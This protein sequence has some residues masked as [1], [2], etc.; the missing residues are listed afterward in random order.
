MR[1]VG[2]RFPYEPERPSDPILF[3]KWCQ[4]RKLGFEKRSYPNYGFKDSR[5]FIYR[6]KLERCFEAHDGCVNTIAWNQ[7]GRLLL[8]GSDDLLLKISDPFE[9]RILTTIQSGHRSNIFSAK[10]LPFSDDAKIVSCSGDGQLMYTEVL[11]PDT[12]GSFRFTC[13]QGSTANVETIEQEPNSFMSCGEDGTVR[14]FDIRTRTSCKK[15]FRCNHD[16]IYKSSCGVSSLAVNQLVPYQM[17]VCCTDGIVRLMD[18]RFMH[19]TGSNRDLKGAFIRFCPLKSP[20]EGE[21][22]DRPVRKRI[23]SVKF[24]P[25]TGQEVLVSYS[26]DSLYLFGVDGKYSCYRRSA[27]EQVLCSERQTD[28]REAMGT[29]TVSQERTQHIKLPESSEGQPTTEGN[30]DVGSRSIFRRLRIRGD[31][32][33][34]GPQAR[35]QQTARNQA[36]AASTDED[37]AVTITTTNT[38]SGDQG[39]EAGQ[40][41]E[42]RNDSGSGATG[43]GSGRSR[44]TA[45]RL[46][47]I[48]SEL[49]EQQFGD[50]QPQPLGQRQDSNQQSMESLE[51]P[52]SSSQANSAYASQTSGS[53][54]GVQPQQISEITTATDSDRSSLLVMRDLDH[55]VQNIASAP[56]ES[57]TDGRPNVDEEASYEEQRLSYIQQVHEEVRNAPPVDES[58]PASGIVFVREDVSNRGASL[59]NSTDSSGINVYVGTGRSQSEEARTPQLNPH[60]VSTV[61]NPT[62]TTQGNDDSTFVVEPS[63]NPAFSRTASEPLTVQVDSGESQPANQR[64]ETRWANVTSG[65]MSMIRAQNRAVA[66]SAARRRT[67]FRRR[68]RRWNM[69]TDDGANETSNTSNINSETVEGQRSSEDEEETDSGDDDQ[70]KKDAEIL[71]ILG[72]PNAAVRVRFS[73]HRNTRTMIKQANFWGSEHVVTGSDCGHVFIYER[74]SGKLVTVLEADSHVVNGVQPHPTNCVLASSGIDYNI[75][76]WTP[77][78]PP[79]MPPPGHMLELIER[80]IVMQRQTRDLITVPASLML[81]LLAI[82]SNR[83]QRGQDTTSATANDAATEEATRAT[84]DG[85][86]N[87]QDETDELQDRESGTDYSSDSD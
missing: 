3:P 27:N 53:N 10:F 82:A 35:P 36:P 52:G 87:N 17:A 49:L 28:K 73:G 7:N 37:N 11:R 9:G 85:A 78:G 60:S 48:L 55:S 13:H 59:N 79:N 45:A 24:C 57:S 15:R 51:D 18:R 47:N 4:E 33:D 40:L 38:S 64:A 71:G 76:I 42:S 5:S 25:Q 62:I 67:D 75:K 23:T 22:S 74:Y 83:N 32:S 34:T 80:N 1:C 41:E 8:S 77:T 72:L 19:P 20:N 81:R 16:V 2:R 26:G 69:G 30:S 70:Q 63:S 54:Q 86:D 84:N 31:W 21:A 12:Y 65:L 14:L 56:S 6:L 68:P 43:G 61:S 46:G 50:S 66:T 44:V 58:D 29:S 39:Q